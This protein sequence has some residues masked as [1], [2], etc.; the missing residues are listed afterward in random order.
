MEKQGAS[1]ERGALAT[2]PATPSKPS[3]GDGDDSSNG[4]AKLVQRRLLLPLTAVFLVLVGSFAAILTITQQERVQREDMNKLRLA[5]G[6]LGGNLREQSRMLAAVEEA[7]LGNAVLRSAL[8]TRDR[9]RLLAE[10]GPLFVRLRDDYRITHFYLHLPDRVN[11]LRV[12]KPEKYGDRI[13][14]HTAR[15]AEKTGQTASGIEIGPLGT[16]TLRVVRPVRDGDTLL[17]YVELGKEI[18]DILENIRAEHGIELAV[19][20]RKDK[21]DRSRWEEGMKMLGRKADW[22]QLAG[23]VLIYSSMPVLPAEFTALADPDPDHRDGIKTQAELA[24]GT[25]H[26]VATPLAD[27]A[28]ARVGELIVMRDV[29]ED[30]TAARRLIV[31]TSGV[32]LALMCGLL[33]YLYIALRQTDASIRAQEGEMHALLTFQN[34]L[35]EALPDFVLILDADC[36]VRTVNRVQPGHREED[37]IGRNAEEFIP[38]EYRQAFREAF[39][40]A[41]DTDQVQTVETAVDLP[42]GRRYFLNRLIRIRPPGNE[43]SVALIATDITDRRRA[44]GRYR[45]LYDSSFDAIMTLAPPTWT[46]TAGNRATI[47][48]FGARDE[49]EF[50]SKGPSDISPEY[51]PD[52]QLSSEKAKAVIGK[53]MESGSNFFE[54]TH[55]KLNGTPFPATVLLTRMEEDGKP[56]LQA[57]VRD[58]SARKKAE[59]GLRAA[60][61]E[62]ERVSEALRKETARANELALRA[63]EAS[64]AKSEFLA[65]MSHEIRTPMNAVIGMTELALDTELN[66]EQRH[67]IETV[68]SSA[69]TLLHLINDILDFS[70]IEAGKLSLDVIDFRLRDSIGDALRTLSARAH[71]KNLELACDV[72]PD[73]P[74]ALLGDPG[75]L[76]QILINL[77]GNA[78]KFTEHGEIVVNIGVESRTRDRVVLHVSVADTGIGIPPEKQELVF[79]DFTQADNSTSRRYGGTG[80][81]LAIS[82]RL[83]VMMGGRMWL[84]SPNPDA[85]GGGPGSVFHFTACFGLSSRSAEETIQ[86]DP[87]RLRGMPVLIVDDNETNRRIL[88]RLTQNWGMEPTAVDGGAAA[89]VAI[90]RALQADRKHQIVLLD[91]DMP[92]IDGF[93]VAAHI[94]EDPRLAGTVVILLTSAN[95]SGD[96]A[97]SRE[98]GCDAYLIKP[99]KQSELLDAILLALGTQY[100]KGKLPPS[101]SA[102][103]E[104]PPDDG[105]IGRPLRILVAEDNPVNQELAVRVLKKRGHAPVL[106]SNGKE[107]LAALESNSFDL[108]LM[109]VQMPE[110]DGLEATRH[111]RDPQ[112]A[113]SDHHIPIIAM[114]AHAM[115]GDRERFLE[116]GMNGYVSKPVFAGKLFEAIAAVLAQ[117]EKTHQ[118]PDRPTPGSL[119]EQLL[120]QF[121]GDAEDLREIAELFLQYHE[122]M[123]AD[124]HAGISSGDCGQFG[125]AAHSFKGAVSIFGTG[126]A[127]E[128]ALRLETMGREGESAHAGDV[129][130][131]LESQATDLTR[132]IRELLAEA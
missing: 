104:T 26:A 91:V 25:W 109:D 59:E 121:G 129:Y 80:L 11:L 3:H 126:A 21:L 12:H 15:Q 113:V 107:A 51:Q 1:F 18:E 97:R 99:V 22:P 70:K 71:A 20:I 9:D 101:P 45:L 16:F 43:G 88:S 93:Q 33:C 66:P 27:A 62:A 58:I 41:A 46:F 105:G 8:A 75:R 5:A 130:D 90:E 40:Q 29:S 102:R 53:A 24:G 19:S 6:A 110:M 103:T 64:Q 132:A 111:I 95:R 89:A 120:A 10:F 44:E 83:A 76:R 87:S 61:A 31:A 2:G 112:S 77:V 108:V 117:D 69:E 13:D 50:I 52:G 57:T 100:L 39:R 106:V 82:R 85:R 79:A 67:F 32:A 4:A 98:L 34:T 36:I 48:L 35:L 124:I 94:K 56:F 49:E 122:Q 115:S 127:Y 38:P 73:V 63:E 23:S 123:L 7:I 114:T 74:E 54:W 72:A 68:G 125:R 119:K 30:R 37:V 116:T 47:D 118:D 128:T 60:L 28:G 84:E 78:A 14:R 86:I 81:G 55:M 42:G 17:G 92:G 65:N 131:V 96:A